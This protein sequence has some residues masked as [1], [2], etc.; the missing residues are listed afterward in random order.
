MAGLLPYLIAALL[1][2]L[3]GALLLLVTAERWLV[4]LLSRLDRFLTRLGVGTWSA[5][6]LTGVEDWARARR[7]RRLAGRDG[8]SHHGGGEAR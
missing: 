7:E 6:L 4:A 5:K 8:R 3:L 1:L 2:L